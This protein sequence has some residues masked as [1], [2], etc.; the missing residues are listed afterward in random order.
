LKLVAEV[1]I[2]QRGIP[3]RRHSLCCAESNVV[4]NTKGF[5][6]Q[7]SWQII[8]DFCVFVLQNFFPAFIRG[9]N[10]VFRNKKVLNKNVKTS[11]Q[12]LIFESE[13]K[14]LYLEAT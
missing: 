8:N 9:N 1:S 10:N 5:I 11:K 6:I 2:A 13:F 12:S 3:P 7:K 4:L 14:Y